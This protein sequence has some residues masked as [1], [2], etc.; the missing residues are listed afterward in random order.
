MSPRKRRFWTTE[1]A[2]MVKF[3]LDSNSLKPDSRLTISG[4]IKEESSLNEVYMRLRKS[5]TVTECKLKFTA[6]KYLFFS[7][8]TSKG[9]EFTV[10]GVL[11]LVTMSSSCKGGMG[12][13]SRFSFN[14]IHTRD[15]TVFPPKRINALPK[16]FSGG[17]RTTD[18]VLS[19]EQN[20]VNYANNASQCKCNANMRI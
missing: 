1:K 16:Y 4:F 15:D 2:G 19:G 9:S 3:T 20:A 17:G 6:S 10:P 14:F 13:P 18:S 7:S 8:S 5:V 12:K 11:I